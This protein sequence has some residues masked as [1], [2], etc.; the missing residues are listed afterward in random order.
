MSLLFKCNKQK[1]FLCNFPLF[2]VTRI[3]IWIRFMR[4]GIQEAEIIQGS[5]KGIWIHNTPLFDL[6]L[7]S[8]VRGKTHMKK[9]KTLLLLLA[10][11]FI[12][13]PL[14]SFMAV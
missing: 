12:P 5:T 8:A 1:V 7:F 14:S 4:I 3:H 9:V 6:A 11:P 13:L 10:V 2:F